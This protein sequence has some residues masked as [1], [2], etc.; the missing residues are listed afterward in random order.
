MRNFQ[1]TFEIHNQSFII[2]YINCMTVPLRTSNFRLS[3]DGLI[4]DSH[5]RLLV[6]YML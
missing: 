1:D 2:A 4:F 3:L 6:K 5:P